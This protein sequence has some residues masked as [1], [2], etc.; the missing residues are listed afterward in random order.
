MTDQTKTK[1]RDILGRGELHRKAYKM[2]LI[3][4]EAL[5]SIGEDLTTDLQRALAEDEDMD[6]EEFHEAFERIEKH[7]KK[8]SK[9]IR[10]LGKFIDKE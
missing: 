8:M 10:V 2:K 5:A 7:S 3:T 9:V 6:F 4:T 1:I